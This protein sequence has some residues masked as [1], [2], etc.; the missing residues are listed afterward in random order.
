MLELKTV[1]DMLLASGSAI[2]LFS[3]AYALKDEDT[4]WSRTSSGINVASYPFTALFP[5]YI[6]GLDY[7]F[8]ISLLNFGIWSGIYLYRAPEDEDW[9]GR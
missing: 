7:T 5:F 1:A 8:T 4:V 9:L 2:G 6:L 3:K